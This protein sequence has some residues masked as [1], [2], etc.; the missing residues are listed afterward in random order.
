M[1]ASS[2]PF[3]GLV[4]FYDAPGGPPRRPAG[5]K[6]NWNVPRCKNGTADFLAAVI[7][8]RPPIVVLLRRTGKIFRCRYNVE[9]QRGP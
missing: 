3:P 7:N 1:M 4:K 2:I 8:S 9:L 5:R 6:Y